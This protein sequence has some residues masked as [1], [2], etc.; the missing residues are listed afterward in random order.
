[1]NVV[2]V[3]DI[4]STPSIYRE[5]AMVKVSATIETRTQIMQLAGV[6]RARVVDV[7]SDS[8]VIETTGT[9]EKIEGLLEVL[10]PYGILELVRTG[11][12]GMIRGKQGVAVEPSD[13]VEDEEPAGDDSDTEVP[14]VSYSV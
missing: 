14:K 5:L 6:F 7:A 8:L 9:E 4:T 11:R 1:M 2:R 3:H 10:R 12:V 13:R